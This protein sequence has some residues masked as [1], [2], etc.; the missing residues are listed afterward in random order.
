MGNVIENLHDTRKVEIPL[1]L[2]Q[3]ASLFVKHATQRSFPA[4]ES[5]SRQLNE[6][7]IEI[8]LHGQNKDLEYAD[9]YSHWLGSLRNTGLKAI[10]E[11]E[12]E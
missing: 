3:L 12:S 4:A 9:L 2:L 8:A 1:R 10:E 6:G 7:I 5:Q 11:E